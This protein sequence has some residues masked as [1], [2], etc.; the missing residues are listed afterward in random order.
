MTR[1]EGGERRE[2]TILFS[3]IRGFTAYSE[4]VSAEEVVGWMAHSL[5]LI[6]RPEPLRPAALVESV[7][8]SCLG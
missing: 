1:A 5:G 3:D 7:V 6:P 8:F 2:A 4:K